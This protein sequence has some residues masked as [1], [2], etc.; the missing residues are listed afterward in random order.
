[1]FPKYKDSLGPYLPRYSRLPY[2]VR[3]HITGRSRRIL[4]V[5]IICAVLFLVSFGL[6]NKPDT[7]SAPLVSTAGV[8][9]GS[10][11][12]ISKRALC[13]RSIAYEELGV[14]PIAV[15]KVLLLPVLRTEETENY[16]DRLEVLDDAMINDVAF[17]DRGV[18]GK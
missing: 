16:A 1:M 12:Y 7:K 6:A 4:L 13:S 5:N 15:S 10:V 11:Y 9:S 14:Q 17:L 18:T 2:I 8:N 3:K